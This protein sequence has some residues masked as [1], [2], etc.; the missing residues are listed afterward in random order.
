[1]SKTEKKLYKSNSSNSIA[2]A[3]TN[4]YSRSSSNSVNNILDNLTSK[5]VGTT[6]LTSPSSSSSSSSSSSFNSIKID[7]K[8]VDRAFRIACNIDT[9]H[10]MLSRLSEEL[11]KL[12]KIYRLM[13]LKLYVY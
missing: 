7:L 9:G 10:C 12:G 4:S 8:K 5:S 2:I 6:S 13:I 3:N 11:R 1:M